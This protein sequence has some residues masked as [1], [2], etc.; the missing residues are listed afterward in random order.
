MAKT[1]IA[2][3][4]SFKGPARMAAASTATVPSDI[5]VLFEIREMFNAG[6]LEQAEY[7]QRRLQLID[8]LT[9][10]VPSR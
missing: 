1:A 4:R 2:K 5:K 10:T 3:L 9:N 8:D 7:N 6:F